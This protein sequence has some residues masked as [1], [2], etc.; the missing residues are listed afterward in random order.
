MAR[1]IHFL[2]KKARS[3]REEVLTMAFKANGA[4]IS[5][6]LCIADILTV[7]YWD[8]MQIKPKDPLYKNR[9]R[10]I[11]SKG[12]AASA[13]FAILY[14]REFFQDQYLR[15]MERTEVFWEFIPN[16]SCQ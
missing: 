9:D 16:I 7:L 12:H 14:Q 11:L 8:I 2:E 15:P 1:S 5:S 13:L 3:L 6:S 4:H 10:F